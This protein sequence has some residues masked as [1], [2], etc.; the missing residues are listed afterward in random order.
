MLG[1]KELKEEINKRQADH[2]KLKNQYVLKNMFSDPAS[3]KRSNDRKMAELKESL[4]TPTFKPDNLLDLNISDDNGQTLVHYI[5]QMSPATLDHITS[6]DTAHKI[7]YDK[8]DNDLNTPLHIC[9]SVDACKLLIERASDV[10]V[11]NAMGDTFAHIMLRSKDFTENQKNELLELLFNKNYKYDLFDKDSNSLLHIAVDMGLNEVANLLMKLDKVIDLKRMINHKNNN[12]ENVG[13]ILFKKEQNDVLLRELINKGLNVDEIDNNGDTLLHLCIKQNH[14]VYFNILIEFPIN[15]NIPNSKGEYI[16]GLAVN[17]MFDGNKH[18]FNEL[19]NDKDTLKLDVNNGIGKKSPLHLLMESDKFTEKILGE[20]IALGIDINKLDETNLTILHY[21]IKKYP[22]MAKTLMENDGYEFNYNLT[23]NPYIDYVLTHVKDPNP[24]IT[25]LITTLI[26]KGAYVAPTPL[27]STF[28]NWPLYKPFTTSIVNKN[29]MKDNRIITTQV[30]TPVPN[31][32]YKDDPTPI[33]LTKITDPLDPYQVIQLKKPKTESYFRYSI[34]L[35]NYN[36]TD[37]YSVFLRLALK[38]NQNDSIGQLILETPDPN[39]PLKYYLH[40]YTDS[41]ANP[42]S[43]LGINEENFLNEQT[44]ANLDPTMTPIM[45]YYKFGLFSTKTGAFYGNAKME[46]FKVTEDKDGKIFYEGDKFL[47]NEGKLYKNVLY[48]GKEYNVYCDL[49]KMAPKYV[50][51]SI[52]TTVPPSFVKTYYTNCYFKQFN[53]TSYIITEFKYDSQNTVESPLPK[54]IPYYTFPEFTVVADVKRADDFLNVH[55]VFIASCRAP[56]TGSWVDIFREHGEWS[57]GKELKNPPYTYDFSGQMADL[58]DIL[59]GSTLLPFD[60]NTHNLVI[61]KQDTPKP[62]Y[63][64]EITHK[65]TDLTLLYKVLENAIKSSHTP[66]ISLSKSGIFYTIKFYV[67]SDVHFIGTVNNLFTNTFW[68]ET[69]ISP[70]KDSEPKVGFY[71]FGVSEDYYGNTEFEMIPITDKTDTSFQLNGKTH[72]HDS[73]F[74]HGLVDENAFRIYYDIINGHQVPYTKKE[75]DLTFYYE[76]CITRTFKIDSPT[77]FPDSSKLKPLNFNLPI[78]NLP[79]KPPFYDLDAHYKTICDYNNLAT[80]EETLLNIQF[81]TKKSVNFQI[82]TTNPIIPSSLTSILYK[83]PY[84]DFDYTKHT[85]VITKNPQKSDYYYTVSLKP[86]TPVSEDV[87]KSIYK[88]ILIAR[89]VSVITIDISDNI[90]IK[91][92]VDDKVNFTQTISSDNFIFTRPEWRDIQRLFNHKTENTKPR[93][94]VW[95]LGIY[96]KDGKHYYGNTDFKILEIEKKDDYIKYGTD[97]YFFDKDIPYCYVLEQTTHKKIYIDIGEKGNGKIPDSNKYFNVKDDSITVYYEECIMGQ[98]RLGTTEFSYTLFGQSLNPDID[99][100]KP[101]KFGFKIDNSRSTIKHEPDFLE[102]SFN[103]KCNTETFEGHKNILK[104]LGDAG[105]NF[106]VIDIPL[107][108]PTVINQ[109][110]LPESFAYILSASAYDKN[111]FNPEKQVRV[112]NNGTNMS[113]GRPFG[114]YVYTIPVKSITEIYTLLDEL[115]I[116]TIPINYILIGKNFVKLYA[117]SKTPLYRGIEPVMGWFKVGLYEVGNEWF[118][119]DVHNYKI[120]PVVKSD[121]TIIYNKTTYNIKDELIY[122]MIDNQF[123]Y[124]DLGKKV[125]FYK[126][127]KGDYYT[128]YENEKVI[129]YNPTEDKE[130]VFKYE[131][132]ADLSIDRVTSVRAKDELYNFNLV[133][134]LGKSTDTS[135]QYDLY[136]KFKEIVEYKYES[137]I[138]NKLNNSEWTINFEYKYKQPTSLTPVPA[139]PLTTLIDLLKTHKESSQKIVLKNNNLKNYY[140]Y[141]FKLTDKNKLYKLIIKLTNPPYKTNYITI[142]LFPKYTVRLY[143]NHGTILFD[144]TN[145]DSLFTTDFWINELG[146]DETIQNS[147]IIGEFNYGK[148]TLIP[149]EYYF[150]N[151]DGSIEPIIANAGENSFKTSNGEKYYVG[152]NNLLYKVIKGTEQFIYTDLNNEVIYYDDNKI[153]RYHS[154]DNQCTI[155]KIESDNNTTYYDIKDQTTP[156]IQDYKTPYPTGY[157][158]FPLTLINQSLPSFDNQYDLKNHFIE[159]KCKEKGATKL[160]ILEKLEDNYWFFGKQLI[161]HNLDTI[162]IPIGTLNSRD[163]FNKLIDQH[164]KRDVL[165]TT[166]ENIILY[167]NRNI[168]NYANEISFS[169]YETIFVILD[170]L[171]NTY[172]YVTI[173]KTDKMYK[174]SLYSENPIDLIDDIKN[175]PN[176]SIL[177][178]VYKKFQLGYY[179]HADDTYYGDINFTVTKLNTT[180]P[181]TDSAINISDKIYNLVDNKIYKKYYDTYV[182]TSINGKILYYVDGG[183][184]YTFYE[185]GIIRRY[186]YVDN[187]H[188]ILWSKYEPLQNTTISDISPPEP[189]PPKYNFSRLVSSDKEPLPDPPTQFDLQNYFFNEINYATTDWI[190]AKLSESPYRLGKESIFAYKSYPVETKPITLLDTYLNSIGVTER[191]VLYKNAVTRYDTKPKYYFAVKTDNKTNLYKI[192][193]NPTSIDYITIDPQGTL[194]EIRFYVNNDI[195]EISQLFAPDILAD[196]KFKLITPIPKISYFQ[197]GYYVVGEKGYYGNFDGSIAEMVEKTDNVITNDF[198]EYYINPNNNLRYKVS[199]TESKNFVYVDLAKPK[200]NYVYISSGMILFRFYTN[201]IYTMFELNPTHQPLVINKY[202]DSIYQ[203][204]PTNTPKYLD[205]TTTTNYDE[206]TRYD[207]KILQTEFSDQLIANPNTLSQLDIRELHFFKACREKD[208]KWII[209]KLFALQPNWTLTITPKK[210]SI[211]SNIIDLFKNLENNPILTKTGP[212]GTHYLLIPSITEDELKTFITSITDDTPMTGFEITKNDKGKYKLII[213]VNEDANKADLNLPDRIIRNDKIIPINDLITVYIDD[214]PVL[215]NPFTGEYYL[216]V[217]DD[218]ELDTKKILIIKEGG[219]KILSGGKKARRVIYK[220]SNLEDM[221]QFI[222]KNKKSISKNNIVSL[223]QLKAVDLAKVSDI[224][225]IHTY[226]DFLID[227]GAI[228]IKI[229][230]KE[231]TNELIINFPYNKTTTILHLIKYINRELKDKKIKYSI[232]FIINTLIKKIYNNDMLIYKIALSDEGFLRGINDLKDIKGDDYNFD[233]Y[234]DIVP[235]SGGGDCLFLAVLQAFPN[236]TFNYTFLNDIKNNTSTL[237]TN[238]SNIELNNDA[239]VLRYIIVDRLKEKLKDPS[240]KQSIEKSYTRQI[241]ENSH[242]QLIKNEGKITDEEYEDWFNAMITQNY[243]GGILEIQLLEELF[244]ITILIYQRNYNKFYCNPNIFFIEQL[245]NLERV[246]LLNNSDNIHYEL[247]KVYNGMAIIDNET[248]KTTG[249]YSKYVKECKLEYLRDHIKL[250]EDIRN[251]LMNIINGTDVDNNQILFNTLWSGF[252]NSHY[253]NSIYAAYISDLKRAY[254]NIIVYITNYPP[255]LPKDKFI[256]SLNNCKINNFEKCILDHTHEIDNPYSHYNPENDLPKEIPQTLAPR[257]PLRPGALVPAPVPIPNTVINLPLEGGSLSRPPQKRYIL[258]R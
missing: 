179:T 23:T 198:K 152:N 132:K 154:F 147:P 13:H 176:I 225:H 123:V 52:D 15:V 166:K 239:K 223:K 195:T 145:P 182:H 81:I 127:D 54:E 57:I 151:F 191:I 105:F 86:N 20:F 219:S 112:I 158:D 84:P 37:I 71:K 10:N 114:P 209:S 173:N 148:Y 41:D 224:S 98:M 133:T 97:V 73:G 47:H 111:K 9:K 26:S 207:F 122:E 232:N 141:E 101:F 104:K 165:D 82:P 32:E 121:D 75:S 72:Y 217:E 234:F 161:N 55:D 11:R 28:L 116:P 95:Q 170:T 177:E 118:Y 2:D 189:L 1:E 129:E 168:N 204:S 248:F 244:K 94:G 208:D 200:N 136:G 183:I 215:F 242:K 4:K 185:G 17:K 193:I 188:K 89:N 91:F 100:L 117:T 77:L 88:M 21:A 6:L 93:L 167:R 243:W 216:I 27:L 150:G 113:N 229:D 164:V 34:E 126:G 99:S 194:Y 62:E 61:S 246:V 39:N 56:F 253:N 110:I 256:T 125:Y 19:I 14:Q 12:G 85:L 3:I 106:G 181:Q 163:Y 24:L 236:T 174:I 245:Y 60:Y 74:V 250:T 199:K 119:G 190:K 16:F 33:S 153:I 184:T 65:F 227:T 36:P 120:Y 115:P 228:S 186:R 231:K 230:Y 139:A 235:N 108:N 92:W 206:L 102:T 30:P 96:E 205:I 134:S 46:V 50:F 212:K 196:Y 67:G 220:S 51:C 138:K 160:N 143:V 180:V 18:Y 135:T 79:N 254:D 241:N 222:L 210:T 103:T 144:K 128:Y 42:L 7:I 249:L 214:I 8:P 213:F 155:T 107:N 53:P 25:S 221:K 43:S 237:Y 201:C 255:V 247:I 22:E 80:L 169:N 137:W 233:R 109:V 83:I 211:P 5:A 63:Y 251:A 252:I 238:G 44:V 172:N 87:V 130:T 68:N 175:I 45:R 29:I 58:V 202:Y 142:D 159:T 257:I 157:R 69:K 156:I 40:I 70:P 140:Y 64:Y 66:Y 197:F 149:N 131:I 124:R 171:D 146:M 90:T 178:K 192:A 226:S 218:K 48:D 31:Y 258:K 76:N 35:L 59:S 240:Y 78:T 162:P 38:F 187:T 49:I 203:Y